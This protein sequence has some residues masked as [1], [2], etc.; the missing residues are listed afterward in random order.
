MSENCDH[1]WFLWQCSHCDSEAFLC[2]HCGADE[3][4]V[5][6]RN[7]FKLATSWCFAVAAMG[8]LPASHVGNEKKQEK[9]T[10]EH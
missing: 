6:L 9:K 3:V 7:R 1:E 10:S 5:T 8:R 2:E 4:I